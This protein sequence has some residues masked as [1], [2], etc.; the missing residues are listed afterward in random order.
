MSSLKI[1]FIL[2]FAFIAFSVET[3]VY[4]PCFPDMVNAL[5]VGETSIQKVLSLNFLGICLSCFFSGPLS[6]SF[7]RKKVLSIGT[8]LFALASLICYLSNQFEIILLGRFIQG[9]GA[10]TILAVACTCIFDLYEPTKSGQLV[11]VLNAVVTV[12]MAFAPLVGVWLNAQFGWKSCF[13]FIFGLA[14]ITWIGVAFFLPETHPA[15]K[16][17]PFRPAFILSDYI[18]LLK[19]RRFML[20][21]FVWSFM[22]TTLIVYTANVSLLFIGH[23]RTSEASFGFYQSI[24]MTSFALFSLACSYLIGRFGG[25]K[26]RILGTILFFAGILGLLAVNYYAPTSPLLISAAM[27]IVA[28]GTGLAVVVYFTDSMVGVANAGVAI[29]LVQGLRLF[30]AAQLTD[31]SRILFDGSVGSITLV[32]A[33][34]AMATLG[35]IAFLPKPDSSELLSELP[36]EVHGVL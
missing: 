14:S 1:L 4:V 29:S 12:T 28:A 11:S 19:S 23:L 2:T 5:G 16:R 26:V 35:C 33:A 32:L 13:L 27:A 21:S 18:H 25:S 7:G 24:T 17:K 10:G 9:L 8:G 36:S 15:P 34:I 30:L 6:D 20:G 3:D 22:F 31:L